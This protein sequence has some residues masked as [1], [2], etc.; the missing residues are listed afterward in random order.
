[1]IATVAGEILSGGVDSST[2]VGTMA[3]SPNDPF[4]PTPWAS[5]SRPSTKP[6][7]LAAWR[8]ATRPIITRKLIPHPDAVSAAEMLTRHFPL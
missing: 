4:P 1:M 2:V 7:R 5:T 8:N 3:R 6:R